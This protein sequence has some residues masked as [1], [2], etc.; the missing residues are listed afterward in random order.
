MVPGAAEAIA[1]STGASTAGKV[2][3]EYT[4]LPTAGGGSTVVGGPHTGLP[5]T[6]QKSY[7]PTPTTLPG[8][9]QTPAT[10]PVDP[11]SPWANVP[12][13]PISSAIGA[14]NDFTKNVLKGAADK[15]QELVTKYGNEADI[16][17]QKMNYNNEA[18]KALPNAEVG[19]LSHFFTEN[20]AKMQEWGVSPKLIPGSGSVTPTFELN[21]N[22]L[23]SALN[24]AKQIYGA[25]MTGNEVMLQKNEASP[26]V[27]TS[28]AAIKSLIS[29]DNARNAYF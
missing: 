20:R 4:T 7:F 29:Q 19:P 17:D 18:L 9:P 14:P 13:L 26:S 12:K 5:P 3:N 1:Q 27:A 21:K 2:A 8:P 22:L 23:N 11:N 10:P 25:R 24:G 6:Q 15:H 16:A 28:Q